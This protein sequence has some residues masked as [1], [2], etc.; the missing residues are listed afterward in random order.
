MDRYEDKPGEGD[1]SEEGQGSGE[2]G[3]SPGG[4]SGPVDQ[5][6]DRENVT[7]KWKFQKNLPIQGRMA[8]VIRQTIEATK[9]QIE[10]ER[11]KLRKMQ[12]GS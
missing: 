11:K 2:Q 7:P 9:K 8:D 12:Y 4:D 1:P 10:A 5:A 6:S 3:Q